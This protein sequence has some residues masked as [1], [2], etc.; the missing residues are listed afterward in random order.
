MQSL[1]SLTVLK[2]DSPKKL[3][4]KQEQIKEMK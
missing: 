2:E 3:V 4:K 1:A